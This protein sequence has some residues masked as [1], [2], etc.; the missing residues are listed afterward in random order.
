MTSGA[1]MVYPNVVASRLVRLLYL[2]LFYHI[3]ATN[4]VVETSEPLFSYTVTRI[5]NGHIDL[6]LL[7]AVGKLTFKAPS[8]Q[9]G[10]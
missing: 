5:T 9:T 2:R 10:M 8:M 3:Q 7:R 6:P 4:A 1:E